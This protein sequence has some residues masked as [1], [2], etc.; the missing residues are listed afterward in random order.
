MAKSGRITEGYIAFLKYGKDDGSLK[1]MILEYLDEN[2][3]PYQFI[4]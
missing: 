2:H 4:I 3:Q 1:K